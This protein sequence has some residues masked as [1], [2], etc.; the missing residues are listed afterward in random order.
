MGENMPNDFQDA[1]PQPPQN[2]SPPP[3]PPIS[4]LPQQTAPKGFALP[5]SNGIYFGL[6]ALF[7]VVVFIAAPGKS[8]EEAGEHTGRLVAF[9]LLPLLLAW[10]AWRCAGKNA[11]VAS[12]MFNIVLTLCV[13]GQVRQ[14]LKITKQDATLAE[15]ERNAETLRREIASTDDPSR[16]EEAHEKYT[17]SVRRGF[18]ELAKNNPDP[19]KRANKILRRDL[20]EAVAAA[21]DWL[22]ARTAILS[23]TTIDHAL[24]TDD[25]EYDRRRDILAIYISKTKSY[26]NS[27]I[28][29]V[30]ALIKEL[31]ALG[32]EDQFAKGAI[33][34]ARA[35]YLKQKPFFE[36]LMQAH[37]STGRTAIRI[38]DFLQKNK[39]K[40]VQQDDQTVFDSNRELA[41]FNDLQ[42]AINKSEQTIRTLSDKLAKVR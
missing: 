23:T 19:Q 41:E 37:I 12:L 25:G 16:I 6:V 27:W 13:L 34:G 40:W 22:E 11:A 14:F 3:I 31:D 1:A 8:P 39:D 30:P 4:P 36:K 21:E 5:R 15:I 20:D 35:Q 17:D 2:T 29:R 26:R 9:I 33:N 10:I 18:D 7:C 24:L 42:D 38:L 28:D 32:D